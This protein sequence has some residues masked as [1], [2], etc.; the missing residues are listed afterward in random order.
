MT[1]KNDPSMK[2][3]HAVQKY[4]YELDALSASMQIMINESKQILDAEEKGNKV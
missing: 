4:I 3:I 1:N 2:L